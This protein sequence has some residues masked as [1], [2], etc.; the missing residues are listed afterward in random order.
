MYRDDEAVFASLPGLP[1]TIIAGISK[2]KIRTCT[3]NSGRK[4][5]LVIFGLPGF[6]FLISQVFRGSL[7][8][9]SEKNKNPSGVPLLLTTP[10]H[11]LYKFAFGRFATN[12]TLLSA[13]ARWF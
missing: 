1:T 10:A 11:Y 13:I 5:F 3:N 6:T 9:I 2:S 7:K 4:F 8:R 12:E